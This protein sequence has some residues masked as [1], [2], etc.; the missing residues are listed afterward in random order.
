MKEERKSSTTRASWITTFTTRTSSEYWTWMSFLFENSLDIFL[1]MFKEHP[2]W[3]SWRHSWAGLCPHYLSWSLVLCTPLCLF[4]SY[5]HSFWVYPTL[6]PQYDRWRPIHWRNQ[7]ENL[8]VQDWA[9]WDVWLTPPSR[10]RNREPV[11]PIVLGLTRIANA[12]SKSWNCRKRP[13][14]RQLTGRD[15]W[16]KT[17]GYLGSW[18]LVK[19]GALLTSWIAGSYLWRKPLPSKVLR[20]EASGEDYWPVSK[21]KIYGVS[22]RRF[23]AIP[24]NALQRNQPAPPSPTACPYLIGK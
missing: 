9:G 23:F 12:P 1:V 7:R 2:S 14:K 24:C 4:S 5:I 15:C 21:E 6:M 16:R 13:E 11:L 3:A 17:V 10:C 19:W 20:A 18:A 8:R 22:L